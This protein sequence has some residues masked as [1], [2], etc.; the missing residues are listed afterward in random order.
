MASKKLIA[1]TEKKFIL[2]Q[3]QRF[4]T[5]IYYKQNMKC[6]NGYNTWHCEPI[7]PTAE[8]SC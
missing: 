2:Y 1:L 7:K 5:M 4:Y 6:C 8:S 3:W